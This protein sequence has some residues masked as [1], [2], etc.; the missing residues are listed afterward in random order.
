MGNLVSNQGSQG[1]EKLEGLLVRFSF[2]EQPTGAW[3]TT[4]A[5]FA[6]VLT[7]DRGPIRVVDVG[8]A[9]ADRDT[10]PWLRA[11]LQ[12]ARDRTT[13]IVGGRGAPAQG[14]R[15]IAP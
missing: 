7:D 15:P 6:P 2:T 14:L 11:R 12:T 5:E 8:R 13:A 3:R 10:D 9:L 1:P 4:R